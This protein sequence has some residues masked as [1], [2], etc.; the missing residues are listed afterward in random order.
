MAAIQEYLERLAASLD[1]P[2]RQKRRVLEEVAAH[3][4]DEKARAALAGEDEAEA[5]RLAIE[6]FGD[7]DILAGLMQSALERRARLDRLVA[8]GALLCLV[9][10]TAH[11]LLMQMMASKL[12]DLSLAAR[13]NAAQTILWVVIVVAM[14]FAAARASQASLP[15]LIAAGL[16]VAGA[17]WAADMLWSG[18]PV[19]RLTLADCLGWTAPDA[20]FFL[21]LLFWFGGPTLLVSAVVLLRGRGLAGVRACAGL[22]ALALVAAAVWAF[23]H[24]LQPHGLAELGGFLRAPFFAALFAWLTVALASPR[25]SGLHGL[26][27]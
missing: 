16:C 18:W 5:E 2:S 22:C 13:A 7:E 10:V 27:G 23:H 20:H 26:P 17:Q 6:R 4:E 15:R 8:G 25:E 9:S 14:P 21:L 11:S 12:C 1:L 3:L 24:R 19:V